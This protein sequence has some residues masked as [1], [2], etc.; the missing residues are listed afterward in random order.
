MNVS[1]LMQLANH[2]E[3]FTDVESCVF[4]YKDVQIVK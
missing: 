1:K 4:L 2:R 3:H